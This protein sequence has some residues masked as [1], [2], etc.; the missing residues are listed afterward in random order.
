M[1][2]SIL[3]RIDPRIYALVQLPL[4]TGTLKYAM[5]AKL[6]HRVNATKV[7]SKTGNMPSRNDLSG[8]DQRQE[9][10]KQSACF[11]RVGSVA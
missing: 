9:V 10:R 1:R 7:R 11:H 2:V 6:D 8:D 3:S 5:S 4:L